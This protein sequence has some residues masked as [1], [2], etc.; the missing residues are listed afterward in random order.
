MTALVVVLIVTCAV[1]A[2][3]GVA[4][5]VS[6]VGR[7]ARVP[8][9]G[10]E[11]GLG[12]LT[13][14]VHTGAERA[15]VG[16][17]RELGLPRS[18]GGVEYG[19]FYIEMQADTGIRVRSR[20]MIGRGFVGSVRMSR[21]RRATS[22]VYSILRLPDDESLHVAVLGLE[23]ELVGALRRIDPEASVRLSS[24]AFREM[25][26]VGLPAEWNHRRERWFAAS[27]EP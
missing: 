12:R 26:R 17:V 7:A 18:P 3:A 6:V 1:S 21:G 14:E 19:G 22:V 24:T 8:P 9:P 15:A 2:G 5:A 20:S 27:D 4:I 16:L 25:K 10:L 11:A 23:L 13:A